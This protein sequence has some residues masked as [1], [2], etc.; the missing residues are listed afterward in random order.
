M[1]DTLNAKAALYAADEL[2][3]ALDLKLPVMV[4]G[5]ITDL[6]GRNLSGQTAEAFGTR[7]GIH[8]R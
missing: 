3:E 4:S 7:C 6:S 1:F 2:F 5:T 8:G